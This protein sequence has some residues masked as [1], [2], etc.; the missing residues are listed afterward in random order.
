MLLHHPP[1]LHKP[2]REP[3]PERPRGAGRRCWRAPAPTW[4]CTA[5]ITATSCANVARAGGHA[6][7]VVGAG[8]AS[9]AG[10]R[11]R[12]ARYNVYEI[13][14]R[15]ITAVT[16]AHDEKSERFLQVRRDPLRVSPHCRPDR[17]QEAFI[18]GPL[19]PAAGERARERGLHFPSTRAPSP[20]PLPHATRGRGEIR[21]T[22]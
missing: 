8:S 4:S 1:V 18:S 19:A 16:Y 17:T 2:P 12:R 6:I 14:G 9:Y 5:T 13:E 3:Q 22:A 20:P 10:G 7:P 11:R 15:T 21:G